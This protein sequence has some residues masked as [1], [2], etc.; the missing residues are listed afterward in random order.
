MNFGNPQGLRT[1]LQAQDPDMYL[2]H[3]GDTCPMGRY[4]TELNGF[5]V[6]AGARACN[7]GTTVHHSP[8]WMVTFIVNWDSLAAYTARQALA[9]LERIFPMQPMTPDLADDTPVTATELGYR[10]PLT[11]DNFMATFQWT[12]TYGTYVKIPHAAI[13]QAAKLLAEEPEVPPATTPPEVPT[14]EPELAC[15]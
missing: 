12:G 8:S 5:Q 3:H 14:Q 1:W 2:G 9:L 10:V 15:V 7:T 6:S 4:L 13:A 11:V